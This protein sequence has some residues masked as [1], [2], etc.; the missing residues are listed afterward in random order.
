MGHEPLMKNRC[1]RSTRQGTEQA[2]WQR[3]PSYGM[4]RVTSMRVLNMP[5]GNGA[6][7]REDYRY[8]SYPIMNKLVGSGFWL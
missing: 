7:P 4:T 1:K 5:V 8:Q 2:C 6:L 3:V